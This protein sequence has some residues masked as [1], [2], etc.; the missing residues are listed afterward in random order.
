MTIIVCA[1]RLSVPSTLNGGFAVRIDPRLQMP[2]NVAA[3]IRDAVGSMSGMPGPFMT[4][5]FAEPLTVE[6]RDGDLWVR[7]ATGEEVTELLTSGGYE[8]DDLDWPGDPADAT[9]HVITWQEHSG[10][11]VCMEPGCRVW[12]G[13]VILQSGKGVTGPF[14]VHEAAARAWAFSSALALPR[15]EVFQAQVVPYAVARSAAPGLLRLGD[16]ESRRLMR[17][18]ESPLRSW[19]VPYDVPLPPYGT[20]AAERTE[21]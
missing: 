5:V 10:G 15:A 11:E 4:S 14:Y 16:A 2:E 19:G 3:L 18:W 6:M 9:G 20:Q 21:P 17:F 13:E 12:S 1:S 8:D 7:A